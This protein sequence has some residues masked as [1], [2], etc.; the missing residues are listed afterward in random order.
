MYIITFIAYAWFHASRKPIS[1]V[2]GVL[3]VD[4]TPFSGETAT[5]QLGEIGLAFLLV[6]S[7]EMYFVGHLGD[8][9]NLHIFLTVGLIGS[10]NIVALFGMGYWWNIHNFIFY[11]LVQVV[12]GLFQ[13]TGWP[14]IVWLSTIGP[15]RGREAS[16]CAFGILTRQLVTYVAPWLLQ[17]FYN[18]G[19]DGPSFF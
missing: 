19:G 1:T 11:L 5:T 8:G 9:V 14:S 18:M 12:Q 7:L 3:K 17:L 13:A 6:Y 4:W 15:G 2:K 16:S 10:G